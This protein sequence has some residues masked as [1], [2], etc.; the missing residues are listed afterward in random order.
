MDDPIQIRERVPIDEQ[1]EQMRRQFG[2][3][4]GRLAGQIEALRERLGEETAALAQRFDADISSAGARV[5]AEVYELVDRLREDLSVEGVRV[6][7]TAITTRLERLSA[8]VDDFAES[9]AALRAALAQLADR[10]QG[11]TLSLSTA[12]EDLANAAATGA[13][14]PTEAVRG[15]VATM[16]GLLNSVGERLTALERASNASTHTLSSQPES[17]A[18]KVGDVMREQLAETIERIAV[19]DRR[20]IGLARADHVAAALQEDRDL[21]RERFGSQAE[22]LQT[23]SGS[24]GA[25]YVRVRSLEQSVEQLRRESADDKRRFIEALGVLKDI[26]TLEQ[27]LSARIA[28]DVLRA[29]EAQPQVVEAS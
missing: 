21:A 11:M 27:R 16:V 17:V 20:L 5:A 26:A 6:D 22:Q 23:L 18:T 3:A 1:L 7:M 24:V 19:L 2:A 10:I 28:A 29:I 4:I 14:G 13:A 8:R 9:G 25:M 12:R 15:G